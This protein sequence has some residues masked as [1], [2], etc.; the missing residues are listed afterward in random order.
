MSAPQSSQEAEAKPAPG[1][2][3]TFRRAS[4]APP[5]TPKQSRRQSDVVQCAWRYFGEAGSVIAFLNS[6]HGDLGRQPLQLA[7]ESDE[8]LER[9]E[10][11]LKQM[12]LEA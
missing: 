8:G 9:V 6:S 1:R 10:A 2:S 4:K 3:M 7:I 5:Q 11:L 12:T